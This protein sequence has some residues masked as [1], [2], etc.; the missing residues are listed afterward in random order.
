M[1]VVIA[2]DCTAAGSPEREAQFEWIARYFIQTDLTVTLGTDDSNMRV[3]FPS[4][5]RSH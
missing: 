1:L 2:V 4:Q 5:P 3:E